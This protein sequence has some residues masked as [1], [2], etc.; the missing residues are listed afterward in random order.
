L[1]IQPLLG[2]SRHVGRRL[3]GAL[4]AGELGAPYPESALVACL[5]E[6]GAAPEIA[7]ALRSLDQAGVDAMA[8]AAILKATEEMDHDSST[9]DLV[10]SGP[11]IA[12]LHARDTRRVYEE[13][14]GGAKVSLWAST[15]AFFDG[16]RAFRILA[17]RMDELP[18]LE[19]V[20]LLN[21]QRKP[22][23][24]TKATDL[25]RAFAEK[26]WAKEWPGQRRPQVFYDPRSLAP[27]RPDGVLH[28]KAVVADS[29]AVFVTSANLTEAAFDR[30]IEVGTLTR[31]RVLAESLS[32]H[33]QTLIEQELLQALPAS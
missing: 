33:F 8:I 22:G 9:T 5:G 15:Y 2:L 12:G 14:L 6:E 21:V 30:N 29:E 7:A 25:V 4:A 17:D 27:D 20:L 28:A 19:V 3:V 26:F 11:E 24:T 18:H 16:P 31:N 23:D 1:V 10:W 13:L 32:R